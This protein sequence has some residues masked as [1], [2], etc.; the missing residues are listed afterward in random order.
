MAERDLLLTALVKEVLGPHHGPAETLGADEDPLDEYITGVLAPHQAPSVE[1]DAD[2]ELVGDDDSFFDDQGDAGSGVQPAFDLSSLPSPALDPRSRPASLGLSFNLLG[3]PP[4]VDVCATW[5]R[6]ESTA[7]GGWLRRVHGE[8]WN[9]TDCSQEQQLQVASD[10]RVRLHIRS[11]PENGRWRVSVFLVNMTPCE[12]RPRT[13]HHIFQP[14]IRI[15]CH[16]EVRLVALDE[17]RRH[18]DEAEDQSLDLLF[19]DRESLARGHLT[20]A[21]WRVIDPERPHPQ[22][23]MPAEIPF[24]WEDGAAV[25]DPPTVQRFSPADARTEYVPAIPI[26]APDKTW[27]ASMPAP[28]LDPE[29]LA[30]TWDPADVRAALEPLAA[31]YES[32]IT[33][34]QASVQ[35][36]PVGHRA[37]AAR[38]MATC[39]RLLDRIRA[40]IE[41]LV[42]DADARVAFCFSNRAIA[43]QARWT[44]GRVNAWWPFQ[45]AFQLLNLPAFADRRHADRGICDLLWFPTGGGKTEAYLGLAAFTMAIRRL[46]AIRQGTPHSGDGVAILSRYTLR[47]LTIQQFRR[48]LALITAAELLRVDRGSGVRG[49]RPPACPDRTDWLWGRARLSAGLWVG[50]SVTPNGLQDLT[51]R[52]RSGQIITVRGALSLLEGRGDGE[53]EPAQVLSCPACR[54]VLAVPPDGYRRG[55][56]RVLHLVLGD[57]AGAASPP[58]AADLSSPS[59]NVVSRR[60]TA[61]PDPRYCTLSLEVTFVHEVTPENIDSWFHDQVR[62]LMG[63]D[64]FIVAARASRP[65]Y[66]IR[67]MPWGRRGTEKAVDF[68]VFCPSPDCDLTRNIEWEEHMPAG[69]WP[70][71]PA[72]R[73][74]TGSSTRS[75]I[76]AW[77]V[78]EQVYQWCPSMVVATVDKFARLSFEPRAASIFGNVEVF[79]EHL[80]YHRRW[81]P[82]SGPSTS[83]PAAPLDR[84]R[85]G[86]NVNVERLLPPDLVLQDELHLIEGPLGSMVGIYE[87]AVDELASTGAGTGRTAPKYIASTATVRNADAQVRSLYVRALEVFPS[88]GLRA[89]DSF[90]AQ[91]RPIHPLDADSPGRLHVGVCAPGRGAQTPIVRI[92]SRALQHVEDRRRAGAPPLDLDPFRTLVGYFNAIRELA[93][94]VALTQQ[95]IVQRLSTIGAPP[96]VLT[97]DEPV[98]L[99]SRQDSM[100]LPALLGDLD[101]ALG[102]TSD[103]VNLVVA[104]S[105]FGTGVDVERLGLMVVHGQPKTTSSYIQATGRVGRRSGGLVVTFFRAARPRDLN[106]YEF[107]SAY[108]GS[109]YRYV[110]PITV[111]PFAPRARDRALG[112]VAVALLRQAPEIGSAGTAVPVDERWRV[113]QRLQRG[114]HCRAHEMARGRRDVDVQAVPP[115]MEVRAQAQPGMRRPP[116]GDTQSH[117]AAELDCWQQL[118]ARTG[119]QL[120]YYEST[121]VNPP[122][123]PVVLGDLAHQVARTGVAY[124]DAPNSLRDVE[125]TVT[126]RGWRWGMARPHM[127]IRPSQFVIT[128]GPGSIVET[129]SGPVVV[130]SMDRLFQQIGREPQDFEIVDDRLSRA[131]LAGARIARIPTNAELELPADDPIYPTERFPSWALCT[132]HPPDQILFRVDTGCPRCPPG[133]PARGSAAI[134]FVQACPEGHLDDVNWNVVVHPRGEECRPDH[135]LWHGGG[136]ALRHVTIECPRCGARENFGHAYG[137]PWPCSGQQPEIA[138]PRS[139]GCAQQA[140]IVQ[141]GA[142]NLHMPV[143]TS[144]LTILD[145]PTRLHLVLKDRSILASAG[146]LR[147]HGILDQRNF[148]QELQHAG[149]NQVTLDFIRNAP[150]GEVRQALDQLLDQEEGTARPVR[151]EEFER[152]VRAA[153][154]GAPPVPPASPGSPPLFEVRLADVRRFLGPAGRVQFRVTPVSRL[155]MVLVQTGYQR[156]DPQMAATMSVAF[157]R[158]GRTWFP[159]VEL[160][161]EGVFIDL[162]D[163]PSATAGPRAASWQALYAA[164]AT[165]AIIQHPAHVW[166]HSL[167]HRLL[168]T[169]SVDSGY[170]ST[171]IRER[172]YLTFDDHGEPHGGV[173]LY[174]VQPGGDGTLGGL[175]SLVDSFGRIIDR[176]LRDVGTCSNDPLCAEST[177]AGSE[178]AAC[179]SCLLVSET[180]CEHRNRGLDR[181]LL[182]ENLP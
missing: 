106:H 35:A 65:G 169:L 84:P 62:R 48:A 166:W 104:T 23:P 149:L 103:P 148:M 79:N 30:E 33:R 137:R 27:P 11:R 122:R 69:P 156:V 56:S 46:Q 14:Q 1:L 61:H 9:A 89:D 128:Y 87:T 5:A 71:F 6:Y 150:W 110:E 147:R 44:K 66:F 38:H 173:L 19:R 101:V 64:T 34:E 134:R 60:V 51:Y 63:P 119:G 121:L 100:R 29:R 170:S 95:D 158:G 98:E 140:R 105:M 161:G 2:E 155:R 163:A 146:T 153:S 91:T 171:A 160:F 174:T 32:W 73:S 57:A 132:R 77:T 31:G 80:G 26:N 47:L 182:V 94:A 142:A 83:L 126:V 109:L 18:T 143:V 20:S 28:Q 16:D 45:L 120:V 152:L 129:R 12:E 8:I 7:G 154:H 53:G 50:G 141:R 176:A 78:D 179:Y 167:S 81:C 68:E 114:F 54:T 58:P 49:W 117:T 175:I 133:G 99:S 123:L 70:V 125:S 37:V 112:P 136:R 159:G 145:M 86:R 17:G 130:R 82:P 113:Q 127:E 21:V 144:A 157:D 67:S 15:R 59:I 42:S 97:E 131:E 4:V 92:W 116:A 102:G 3:T 165:P 36:L 76:P 43:L 40:G 111:N 168:T 162:E 138:Q 41:L 72:F 180:S 90:F 24:R 22:V 52:D 75:P 135:F 96:R 88:P 118:A 93:G 115:A 164:A 151:E 55:E 139:P 39:R 172:V 124:E 10:P 177:S 74:Q 178:G 25:F 108:H 107:F 85:V 181:L 13:E